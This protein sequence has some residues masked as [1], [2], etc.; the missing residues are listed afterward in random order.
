MLDQQNKE[1]F[2]RAT[3][4][5]CF[6]HIWAI[7]A[8]AW[9]MA[10]Q[11]G[12][13][14][15]GLGGYAIAGVVLLVLINPMVPWTITGLTLRPL[16]HNALE[17]QVVSVSGCSWSLLAFVACII[18]SLWALTRLPLYAL[19]AFAVAPLVAFIIALIVTYLV[20][21]VSRLRLP[22]GRGRRRP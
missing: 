14:G 17:R 7:L 16:I 3:A 9:Y 11:A 5:L 10:F 1:G 21:S 15:V 19:I 18:W 12:F 22:F 4:G 8:G 6:V 2:A 13:F 20:P